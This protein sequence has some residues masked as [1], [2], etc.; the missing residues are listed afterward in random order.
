MW[1]PLAGHELGLG[2]SVLKE[3]IAGG[4]LQTALSEVG[5]QGLAWKGTQ[6]THLCFSQ[7]ETDLVIKMITVIAVIQR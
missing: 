6:T 1:V 4:C 3:L 2:S 7:R 5:Q